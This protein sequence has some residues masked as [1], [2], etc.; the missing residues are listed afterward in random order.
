LVVQSS[1]DRNGDNGARSL[2]G[3][4]TAKQSEPRWC[5]PQSDG[6]LMAEKQILRLK[7]APRLEQVGDEH[8]ERVQVFSIKARRFMLSLVI[9]GS[10]ESGLVFATRP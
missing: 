4:I 8:S 2:D 1:Q 6:Q 10:L 5:P 9:D 7:P 3:S